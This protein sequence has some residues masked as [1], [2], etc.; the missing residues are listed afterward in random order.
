[1]LARETEFAEE[2][3]DDEG[4]VAWTKDGLIKRASSEPLIPVLGLNVIGSGKFDAVS[5]E[6]GNPA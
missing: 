3:T 4:N 5:G 1:M 6:K 2:L